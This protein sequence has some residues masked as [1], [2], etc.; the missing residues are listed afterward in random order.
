LVITAGPWL[1]DLV[2]LLKPFAEPERQVTA[3]VQP[4]D[5]AKFA[6]GKFPVTLLAVEEGPYYFVPIWGAPGLKVGLHHRFRERG[7]VAELSR[8]P[9]AEDEAIIR[10]G[11]R[12]YAPE[13]NGPFMALRTCF[14]TMTPDLHFIVDKLPGLANVIVASVCSGHG[15]KF[16]P[17]IGEMITDLVTENRSR[18]DLSMFS[19]NRFPSIH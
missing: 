5:P 2:P 11:L 10:Q 19:L 18:N 1:A 8:T 15:Y 6:P 9:S 16:A 14:Y 17:V 13:A 12:R 3:W 4:I 7:N